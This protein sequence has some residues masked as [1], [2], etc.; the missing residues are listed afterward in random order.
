MKIRTFQVSPTTLLLV[1]QALVAG[2]LL[3]LAFSPIDCW[4]LQLL[5]T[6]WLYTLWRE[7]TPRMAATLGFTYGLGAFGVGV[8]WVY[9]SIH[10]YG[11]APPAVAGVITLGFVLLLSSYLALQGYVYRRCCAPPWSLVPGFAATWVLG[12]WLRGWLFTGFP[13][14]YLGYAHVTSV[15]S[16][17]APLFGVL[18]LSFFIAL[19][20]ALLGELSLRWRRSLMPPPLS[21]NPS[22]ASGRGEFVPLPRLRE[23]SMQ[24]HAADLRPRTRFLGRGWGEGNAHTGGGFLGSKRLVLLL[25]GLWIACALLRGIAWTT[26]LAAPPLRVGLVQG[27]VEQ[28]VK[29]DSAHLQEGLNRY[30]TLSAPLWHDDLVVWPETAIPLL[31]QREP[32]LM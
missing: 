13:W 16:G 29:F 21:P 25:S 18:G 26:P 17:L 20:G 23:R 27:N 9:V 22:P 10:D 12:E 11:A 5:S 2:A 15:F 28:S 30:A 3:P 8:S 24:R 19:S 32:A 14:L 31:Y 1:A 6:A 4:P 7:R